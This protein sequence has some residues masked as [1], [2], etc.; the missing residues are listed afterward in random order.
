M[1]MTYIWLINVTNVVQYNYYIA[2]IIIITLKCQGANMNQIF[3][4]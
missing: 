2:H 3:K 1:I 4:A